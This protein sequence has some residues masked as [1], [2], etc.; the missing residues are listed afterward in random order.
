MSAPR[1]ILSI[2]ILIITVIVAP[3]ANGP[4]DSHR[5]TFR[6]NV[7]LV[8]LHV[9]VADPQRRPITNLI[10]DDFIVLENGRPQ[11]V[12]H[13]IS[14]G[15]P[16]DVALLVDGSGSMT[17][18]DQTRRTPERTS[19][20]CHECRTVDEQTGAKICGLSRSGMPPADR[21]R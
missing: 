20:I 18:S 13:F 6:T 2:S 17:P 11:Q 12:S 1:T 14:A 9:N 21:D 7:E 8:V 5:P 3:G 16:L 19:A 15:G 10:K 4:D